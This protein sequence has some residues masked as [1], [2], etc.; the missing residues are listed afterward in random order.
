MEISVT[1]SGGSILFGAMLSLAIIPDA[2]TFACLMIGP[3]YL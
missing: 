1:I 3:E 2:T